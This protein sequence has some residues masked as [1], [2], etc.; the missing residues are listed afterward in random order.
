MIRAM[1]TRDSLERY[2]DA[3]T[4]RGWLARRLSV[5][6][7]A[8]AVPALLTG[9]IL[10]FSP[11]WP[12][13]YPFQYLAVIAAAGFLAGFPAGVMATGSSGVSLWF[14]HQKLD[15]GLATFI[16][17]GFLLSYLGGRRFHAE[18]ARARDKGQLTATLEAVQ[19]GVAIFNT[20]GQLLFANEAE[21]RLNKYPS[22]ESMQQDLTHFATV[23]ELKT[24][25]GDILPLDQWPVARVLRGESLG[26]WELRA[27]RRDIGHEWVFSFSG[28]PVRDTDGNQILAVLVTRDVTERVHAEFALRASA[29]REK[30]ANSV[31]DAFL[32]TLSHELRT[33]LNV[34]LGYSEML[35]KHHRGD[36]HLM[37]M[38]MLINRNAEVLVRIVE[39][40]LDVQRIVAGRLQIEYKWFD[41][42]QTARIACESLRPMATAKRLDVVAQLD[43]V[44]I[45]ADEARVYQVLWNLLSNAIKFTPE[46]GTIRLRVGPG[47]GDTAIVSVEDTGQGIPADFLPHVFERFRQLDMSTTRRHFGMGLG[48][49]VVKHVA[50][51]HGGS[52]GV[53]SA[54][55]GLGSVF[56][57]TL[58]LRRAKR[59]RLGAAG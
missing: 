59:R 46:G 57:V 11:V 16:G 52:V 4:V 55:E 25:A 32:A 42:Q 31:K 27:R 3:F 41:L 51:E 37:R 38:T 9:V 34:I 35:K 20:R 23:Y 39:D 40:L 36:E 14:L 45:E 43:P 29:A 19:D 13:P 33:P 30:E 44:R 48:L 6:A 15:A 8:V 49:A 18:A 47:D 54:G 50:Q 2:R 28:A 1:S 22:A 5:Q 26:Q 10:A 21:A 12:S 17:L 58:P 7:A 53:V 24:L 56:T